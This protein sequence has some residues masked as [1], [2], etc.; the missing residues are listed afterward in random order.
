MRVQIVIPARLASTR[1]PEKLL[2]SVGGKS[3]LQHTYESASKSSVAAGVIVAVDDPRLAAAVDSFGG[4]VRLTSP[5]CQSGTDRVA[6]IAQEMSDVEIFV[7]VQGD[8]PEIDPAAIDLVA[9][10]LID[11]PEADIVTVAKPIRDAET[12][13]NPNCVKVVIGN[14]RRA[15]YFSRSVVPYARDGITP[16]LLQQESPLY[17]HHVGLYAYRRDFLLWFA[18]EPP[19]AL[20][21]VEKLEQLRALSAGRHI[22]V[23]RVETA[24][25]GIDTLDD[26]NAF[27]LRFDDTRGQ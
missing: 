12:L 9:Q 4:N 1:L 14:D 3:I 7:N 2:L 22:V 16:G 17:W 20:E 27:A 8:E 25:A 13:V 21:N 26:F 10:T 24:A 23:A 19:A 5:S 18:Q 15:I 11:H 6:E